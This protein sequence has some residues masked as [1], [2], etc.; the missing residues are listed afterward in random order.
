MKIDSKDLDL[1]IEKMQSANLGSIEYSDEEFKIKLSTKKEVIHVANDSL[2]S[3]ANN[4]EVQSNVTNTD[5]NQEQ[6]GIVAMKSPLIGSFYLTPTPDAE[7]FVKVGDRVE[8][9]QKIAVIEAMK[10]ISEI[11][12]EYTGVITEVVQEN[13]NFVDLETVIFKIKI[14]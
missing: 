12:S 14:D 2:S 13:G 3:K 9:G 7:P 10:M 6:P 1:L 4:F 8:V 11:K 5:V